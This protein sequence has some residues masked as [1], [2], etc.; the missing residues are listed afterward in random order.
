LR[1]KYNFGAAPEWAGEVSATNYPSHVK[2]WN[3]N[4]YGYSSQILSFKELFNGMPRWRYDQE[5][6]L[7]QS[8]YLFTGVSWVISANMKNG[9]YSYGS[10][11]FLEGNIL[12]IDSTGGS[13]QLVSGNSAC[14]IEVYPSIRASWMFQG[15]PNVKWMC[16]LS[17]GIDFYRDPQSGEPMW[18]NVEV[19]WVDRVPQEGVWSN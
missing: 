16:L 19:E 17:N 9:N 4:Q 11:N 8:E 3:Q 2:V 1:Q 12:A 14:A 13:I 6:A 5:G 15:N 18:F 10:T 7:Y